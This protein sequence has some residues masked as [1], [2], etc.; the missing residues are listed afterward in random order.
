[1]D[2]TQAKALAERSGNGFQCKVANY[3]RSRNWAVLVSPYYI[4]AST[5]KPR[6]SDLIVEMSFAVKNYF[7]GNTPRSVR[8]RLFIECKYVSEGAVFWMEPMDMPRAQEFVFA[9]TPFI[10]DRARNNDHH[11]FQTS[12]PVAKLF[13]SEQRKGEE[14]DPIYKALNQC[15]NS[16]IHN[17]ERDSLVS[18]IRNEEIITVD[19]PVI[20]CSDFKRFYWTSFAAPADPVP[21]SRNFL[22]ELNYAY[23]DRR[24]C[25]FH[26]YFLVDV[27]DFTAI[28]AFMASLEREA[29]TATFMCEHH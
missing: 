3:F 25:I 2:A 28:D 22:I 21:L 1:L 16:Y 27:V 11:Y 9:R 20:L 10:R 13:A 7:A 19:Y 8:L 15:L 12:E 26:E 4:D 24:K 23:L 14:G 5:D 29:G 6:E 17:G 18:K